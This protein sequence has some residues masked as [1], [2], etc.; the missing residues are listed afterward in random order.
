MKLLIIAALSSLLSVSAFADCKKDF[1]HL[2]NKNLVKLVDVRTVEVTQKRDFKKLR[3]AE[4]KA[5][6]NYISYLNFEFDS[7]TSLTITT[8]QY[9]SKI[10]S[11]SL[12]Y[13]ISVT[14][15]GDEST[16]NY[17]IK[18]DVGRE[19]VAYLILYRVWHNQSP[20]REYLCQTY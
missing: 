1:Y 3:S 9:Q 17:Y 7:E 15:G 2:Q 19:D 8:E 11:E 16:V 12:G 4:L 14:D 13:K 20:E 6:E 10:D 18:I 5:V